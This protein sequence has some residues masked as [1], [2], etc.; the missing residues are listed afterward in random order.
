M[1]RSAWAFKICHQI[2][3][4]LIL[5]ASRNSFNVEVLSLPDFLFTDPIWHPELPVIYRPRCRQAK[6][7]ARLPPSL[8]PTWKRWAEK[9]TQNTVYFSLG[10]PCTSKPETVRSIN[11]NDSPDHW[12]LSA[13]SLVSVVLSPVWL[14]H[15]RLHLDTPRKYWF[16]P[17]LAQLAA[18]NTDVT[19]KRLWQA[20]TSNPLKRA[21]CFCNVMWTRL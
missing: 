15:A 11:R 4:E 18:G 19:Q 6:M 9:V 13:G 21:P 10:F 7:P 1:C 14:C 8:Q 5:K 16:Q 2:K 3:L 12:L 17:S 20:A